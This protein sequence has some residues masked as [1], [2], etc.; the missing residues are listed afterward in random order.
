MKE[1]LKRLARGNFTYD[2]PQLDIDTKR[3]VKAACN[4][5]IRQSFVLKSDLHT[6]GIIW[7]QNDRVVIRNNVF[8]GTECKID[9]EI[10]TK[11]LLPNDSMKGTFDIISISGEKQIPYE[12]QIVD[13]VCE[14]SIGI[15]DTVFDFYN[16]AHQS[17]DEAV[18]FFDSNHFK[19][20]VLRRYFIRQYL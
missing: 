13:K 14:T 1:Y 2:I 5:V 16:L 11:G 20:I 3:I 18:Q 15:V 6:M 12:I 8:S 7:S 17:I 19:N 9:Y 10:Y 4:S